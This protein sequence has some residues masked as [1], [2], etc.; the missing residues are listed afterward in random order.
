MPY[1]LIA[2]VCRDR[3]IGK[4]GTIPWSVPGDLAAFSRITRGN[5]SN[6]IVMGRRTWD[7]LPRRPLPGR[8]NIVLSRTK[9]DK[10]DSD[11]AIRLESLKS[12]DDYCDSRSFEH[13]WVIGGA[14]VYRLF[15]EKEKVDVCAITYIDQHYA[16]DTVLPELGSGWSLRY[17]Q[18][19]PDRMHR[20]ELRQLVRTDSLAEAIPGTNKVLEVALIE[21]LV[22]LGAGNH[23]NRLPGGD[24]GLPPDTPA[25]VRGNR[26][27]GRPDGA[28]KQLRS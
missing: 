18:P 16:C 7:G 20:V 17:V 13:V 4:D 25:A 15:L 3:G 9:A 14:S 8:V 28:T 5:G 10:N 11:G 24:S 22:P 26:L 19:I 2:A 27:P 21:R 1:K 12:L 6:A 23:A